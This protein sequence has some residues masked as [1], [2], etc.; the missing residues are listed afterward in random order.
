MR[1]PRSRA[2]ASSTFS[3]S[4]R[5]AMGSMID[6]MLVTP[7]SKAVWKRMS[8][9]W[10]V[11]STRQ[12]PCMTSKSPS[13][14]SKVTVSLSRSSWS[15]SSQWRMPLRKNTDHWLLISVGVVRLTVTDLTVSTSSGYRSNSTSVSKTAA[16]SPSGSRADTVTSR[17]KQPSLRWRADRSWPVRPRPVPRPKSGTRCRRRPGMPAGSSG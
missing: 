2:R 4:T 3:F 9:P 11:G 5:A 12:L 7:K 16:G 15:R 17:I 6:S 10:A 1:G 14:C 8:Q 13:V